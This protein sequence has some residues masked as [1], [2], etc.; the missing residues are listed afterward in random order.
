[1]TLTAQDVHAR[2]LQAAGR[3]I[4]TSE[5]ARAID[6]AGLGAQLRALVEQIA[7]NAANP[8]ACDVEDAVADAVAVSAATETNATATATSKGS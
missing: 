2:I 5:L 4:A 7:A 6:A 3:Q 8:I 1:M